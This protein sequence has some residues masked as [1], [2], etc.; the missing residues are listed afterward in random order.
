MKNYWLDNYTI[1]GAIKQLREWMETWTQVDFAS[2]TAI[3]D[4]W[5]EFFVQNPQF[6]E[7]ESDMEMDWDATENKDGT[8]W[9]DNIIIWSNRVY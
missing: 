1:E 3:I 2:D 7:F 4:L 5:D 9:F 8:F 6:A